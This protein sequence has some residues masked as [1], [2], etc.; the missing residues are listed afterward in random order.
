MRNGLELRRKT[1]RR[2]CGPL[3]EHERPFQALFD[4]VPDAVLITDDKAR[5][6]DCNPAATR[7]F[8]LGHDDI[9]G[10][11]IKQFLALPDNRSVT[12]VWTASL[13]SIRHRS[14]TEYLVRRP[15]NTRRYVEAAMQAN[16]LPGRHLAI[17]RD[18]TDLR[19]ARRRLATEHTITRHLS[20]AE[21]FDQAAG[22]VLRAIRDGF[23]AD[24]AQLWRHDR[25]TG[26]LLL[27]NACVPAAYRSF[28]REC[29][30]WSLAP[31]EGLAGRV[32][33]SRSPAFITDLARDA[34]L[35]GYAAASK[36]GLR[37]GIAIPVFENDEIFCV[38]EILYRFS[39]EPDDEILSAIHSLTTRLRLYLSRIN[40]ERALAES[41]HELVDFLEN[42]AIG[43]HWAGP[44][45]KILWANQEELDLLGYSKDE[46]IGRNVAEFHVDPRVVEEILNRLRAGEKL[47]DFEAKL[48]RKDDA[49]IDVL[50]NSGAVIEDGR[51]LHTQC[52]TRDISGVKRAEALR[53]ASEE[54]LR[55]IF[56]H[57]ALG[58]AQTDLSGRFLM[59]NPG[60]CQIAGLTKEQALSSGLCELAHPE[61][62]PMLRKRLAMLESD[63]KRSTSEFRFVRPDGSSVWTATSISLSKGTSGVPRYAVA[64]VQDITERKK[65]EQA[66]E[67]ANRTLE[68]AN[69]DL[70]QFSYVASH[71][72]KEPIRTV[73]TYSQLL[74]SRYQTGSNPEAGEIVD[75]IVASARRIH[76]LISDLLRYAQV[77][78]PNL[79]LQFGTVAMDGVLG[80]CLSNLGPHLHEN[81]A[82]LTHDPL[83]EVTGD[84]GDL[85]QLLQQLI[86]NAVKYRGAEPP[87]IHVSARREGSEWVFSV[88]DNGIGIDPKYADRVFLPFKK[89]HGRRYPGNGIGL[90]ICKKVIERH[91]GRIWVESSPG[92]GATFR[93][94]L[95]ANA[96]AA[97]VV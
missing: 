57:V 93:F 7:L 81:C 55:A 44:D 12:D 61:D 83:P 79:L 71:D 76:D 34:G 21:S 3:S 27:D 66:L 25:A 82:T 20:Q 31:G 59:V 64:V 11:G 4:S 33:E 56:S 18:I 19:L 89:L 95:P 1:P 40:T 23:D 85:M 10:Q 62:A 45:G 54:R 50:I 5:L 41:R 26:R 36:C 52:F 77:S 14:K 39:V 24:M 15:D 30:S 72:L 35:P 60:I 68:R 65:A 97:A 74:A 78:D 9:T 28:H 47:R 42:A 87:R 86:G 51:F 70:R 63:G 75:T 96:A 94:T 43:I 67:E 91:G 37:A 38:L 8:G 29:R 58:I 69:E 16:F 80:F 53:V 90:A 46:Y 22:P 32:W 84:F 6:L 13:L 17:L 49:I 73:I 2:S 48:R 88:A 92:A